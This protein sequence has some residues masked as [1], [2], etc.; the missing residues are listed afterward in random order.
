MYVTDFK[1]IHRT[2]GKKRLRCL[3]N[4]DEKQQVEKESEMQEQQLEAHD[5][6]T[7]PLPVTE[8]NAE[9]PTQTVTST[10]TTKN[11]SGGSKRSVCAMHKV[12]MKKAQGK[13]FKVRYNNVG[14][15]V[16]ET[17]H[18]LQS[19]I[20]MLARTTVPINISKWPSVPREFKEKIWD[21]IEV[22]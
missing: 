13:K 6:E 4:Q 16:G 12:L 17:R 21:D 3:K 10:G 5:Q 20:G 14:I 7:G 19:Y 8:R 9:E 22:C 2:M 18:T 15:P 1:E 11:S